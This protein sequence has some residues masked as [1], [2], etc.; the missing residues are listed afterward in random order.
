MRRNPNRLLIVDDD[1][2]IREFIGEAAEELGFLT[3][4]MDSPEEFVLALE[5]FSPSVI[6]L[7]LQMPKADG[8]EFLRVMGEKE[9]AAHVILASGMDTRVLATAEQLG[10]SQGLKMLGTLQKPIMLDD[11]EGL[12]HHAIK[13]QRAI[14][15]EDLRQAL[16][17]HQ[18]CVYYQPKATRKA[19]GSWVVEGVEVLARWLHPVFG[20]VMPEEFIPLAE[21]TGLIGLLTEV[22]F[23]DAIKQSAAWTQQGVKLSIAI[24][25]SA[26]MLDDLQ[27]PD[28]IAALIEE[29][30]ADPKDLMLEITET[31]AMVDPSTTMDILTRLRVKNID[32][33]IDDFGTGYSSL[34]QLYR[35]PF[36]ELK[37]DTSFVTDVCGDGE[38]QALVDTIVLLARRLRM[39]TCA[40]GVESKEVLDYLDNIGCDKA[41]GFYIGLPMPA[42]EVLPIIRAWNAKAAS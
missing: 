31:A 1:P 30:G 33:S 6:M 22:V 25:L 9:T 15:E 13:E 36:S 19:P 7:D 21:E 18:I 14:G 5:D 32:L 35:M 24:N 26:K 2:D 37:I 28:R 17:R 23:R 39:S 12:L 11:L 20:T 8:I 27:L 16:D 3:R 41:Q 10:I 38:A 40:E 34:K 29:S 4:D 42:E